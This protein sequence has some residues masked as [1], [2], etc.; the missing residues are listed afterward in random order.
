MKET[1]I[2]INKMRMKRK[3]KLIENID[4][5]L[6]KNGDTL[7]IINSIYNKESGNMMITCLHNRSGVSF[8]F[9][10]WFNEYRDNSILNNDQYN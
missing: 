7:K 2:C 3:I 1:K 10:L 6:P 9:E 5:Y 4:D 8:D